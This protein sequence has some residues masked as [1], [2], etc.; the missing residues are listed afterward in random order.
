MAEEKQTPKLE[1]APKK[2]KA[3][4]SYT[5][6]AFAENIR[7]LKELDLIEDADVKSLKALHKKAV[8]KWVGQ[9]SV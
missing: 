7:K 6:R 3:S 9:M 8:E 1:D 2:Q 5:L 4:A